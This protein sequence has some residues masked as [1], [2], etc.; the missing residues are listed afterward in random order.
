MPSKEVIDSRYK[1]PDNDLRG[2]YYVTDLTSPLDRP[3]LRYE[4]HGKSPP[5]GRSWRFNRERLDELEREG[6]IFFPPVGLPRL[7]RYLAEASE[8]LWELLTSLSKE[9]SDT[10]ISFVQKAFPRLL[11][12]LDYA[13]NET[14]YE[15]GRGRLRAD[16]VLSRSIEEKPWVIVEAKGRKAKNVAD[17]AYQLRRY[18]AEFDCEKGFVLSPE[19]IILVVGEN[20][21]FIDLKKLTPAKAAE[22][23]GLFDRNAQGEAL[24]RSD[25]R[26]SRLADLIESVESAE[27]NDAKGRSLEILARFLFDDIAPLKSKYGN[28]KTRSSEIDLVVEYDR[29]KGHLPLFEELGRFS[30]IECKNWNKPVGVGPVRDFIGKLQKCNIKLGII[31][32]KSGFTGVDAGLDAVREI[33]S[34]FDRNGIFVLT[35]SLDDVRSISDGQAFIEALDRK[36]DILRFDA[37]SL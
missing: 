16:V 20:T 15:Y 36:A 25:G 12:T 30:L 4:W 1:N 33:Q 8:E 14:F 24:P 19:L 9:D 26:R 5:E 35:F 27:T 6:R 34:V 31:F 7:K 11:R 3:N 29:S 17:W 13:E 23:L 37:Q 18:L 10:E 32:S 22:I 28:L 21:E 2:P